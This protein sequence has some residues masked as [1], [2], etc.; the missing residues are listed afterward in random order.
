MPTELSKFLEMEN[1]KS[2]YLKKKE[3]EFK[4]SKRKEANDKTFL[5]IS[6]HY[7]QA[8]KELIMQINELVMSVDGTAE[9]WGGYS[10]DPSDYIETSEE[11]FNLT[12]EFFQK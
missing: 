4:E 6:N 3:L 1:K 2:P 9:G 11:I 7:S 5:S 10:F 8:E 12:K